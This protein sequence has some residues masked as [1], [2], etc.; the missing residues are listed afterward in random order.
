MSWA[1]YAEDD[2]EI[3]EERM[4]M[5]YHRTVEA[6]AEASYKEKAFVISKPAAPVQV[7]QNFACAAS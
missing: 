7:K 4:Y 3:M 5:K 6:N 1:K 2:M